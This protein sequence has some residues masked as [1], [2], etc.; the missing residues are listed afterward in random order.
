MKKRYLLIFC[1]LV[2]SLPLVI[3]A[4]PQFPNPIDSTFEE[5]LGKLVEWIK[6]IALVLAPLVIIYGGFLHITAAGRPEQS[7]KG[8]KIILYGVIGLIVVLIA[9]SF[10]EIIE[11]LIKE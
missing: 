3:G 11:D 6:G 2:L 9:G 1:F 8:K 4:Q 7:T 10:L 5:L